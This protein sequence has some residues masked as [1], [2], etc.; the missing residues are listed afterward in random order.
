MDGVPEA[1]I[2]AAPFGVIGATMHGRTPVEAKPEAVPPPLPEAAPPPLPEQ[3]RPAA[4]P[5]AE[6]TPPGP[7]VRPEQPAV[8]GRSAGPSATEPVPLLGQLLL[9]ARLTGRRLH[10]GAQRK[11]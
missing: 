4:A 11:S 7:A 5:E 9:A 6:V 3:S 8:A 10:K 1:A 2:S